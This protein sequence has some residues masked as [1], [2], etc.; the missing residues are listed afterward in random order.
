MEIVVRQAVVQDARAIAELHVRSW[1]AAY[2]GLLSDEEIDYF[3]LERRAEGW[4]DLLAEPGDNGQQTLVAVAPDAAIAGFSALSARSRDDDVSEGTGE[5]VAFYVDPRH[6][7]AGV[8]RTMM[9]RSLDELR[10]ARCREATV[11]VLSGNAGARTF[12]ARCGFAPDGLER[13]T[14][15]VLDMRMRMA[16][17]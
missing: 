8:G 15:G 16:L 13:E 2:R 7:R 11:W 14:A 4:V 12:Y 17:A 10:R 9:R 1:E 6:F 5:V 3:T